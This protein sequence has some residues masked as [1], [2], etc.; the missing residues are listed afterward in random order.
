M[1]GPTGGIVEYVSPGDFMTFTAGAA[2]V[3]GNVVYLSADRTVQKAAVLNEPRVIG[4]AIHSAASGDTNLTVCGDG[5]WPLVA[6]GAIAAGD[7]VVA[8]AAVAGTVSTRIAPADPL[9]ANTAATAAINAV[10][11][12]VG[13]ALEAISDTASGRVKLML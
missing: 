7:N 4:V 8:A 13:K 1:A 12:R 2:I 10:L 5:V 3:G 11:G 6:A 9:V